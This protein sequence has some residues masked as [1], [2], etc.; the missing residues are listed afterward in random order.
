MPEDSNFKEGKFYLIMH[1]T[2]FI[3]GYMASAYFAFNTHFS[4]Q[5]VLDEWCNK[6][7]GMCYP[8]CGMMHIKEPL[9]LI[10]LER[11]VHV[12]AAGFLSH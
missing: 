12:A 11:V 1:S 8:V 3:Y 9:L 7:S 5:P 4:F 10:I 2:H 6:S